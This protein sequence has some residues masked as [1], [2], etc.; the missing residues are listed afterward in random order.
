MSWISDPLSVT[1]IQPPHG[2]G[3]GPPV[4][5]ALT[6]NIADLGFAGNPVWAAATATPLGIGDI[7]VFLTYEGSGV[8]AAAV[9]VDTVTTSTPLAEFIN[10]ANSRQACYVCRGVNAASGNIS[11]AF[12]GVI[13]AVTASW[14]L[15]QNGGTPT[16]TVTTISSYTNPTSN[17]VTVPPGGISFSTYILSAPIAYAPI[18]WTGCVASSSLQIQE[19]VTASNGGD[20]YI[21]YAN[22]SGTVTATPTVNWNGQ[23][24][25]FIEIDIP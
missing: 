8:S 11:I 9:T 1:S 4:V 2:G 16:G 17:P 22:A 14:V 3:G 25:C 19:H 12:T 7:Y 6:G 18:A 24:G 21:N 10:G 5:T 13:N 23:G 15:V 20:I